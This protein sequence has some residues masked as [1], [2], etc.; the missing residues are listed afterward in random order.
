MIGGEHFWCCARHYSPAT[1]VALTNAKARS[2]EQEGIRPGGFGIMLASQ[3]INE[4]VF[5]EK[6]NELIFVKYLD[7]NQRA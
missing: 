2:R 7:E 5:N 3:A 1:V 4:L 6:H